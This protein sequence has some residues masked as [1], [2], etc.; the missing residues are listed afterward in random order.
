MISTMRYGGWFANQPESTGASLS[1]AKV[2]N[3]LAATML[4]VGT[5][6]AIG[7]H[8]LRQHQLENVRSS[9]FLKVPTIETAFVRGALDDLARIREVF[10]PAISDLAKALGVSRQAVYNWTNGEQPKPEHLA[11]LSDFAQAADVIA[12]AG[13]PVNGALLKRKIVENK[14]LF[15]VVQS[16]GSAR[17]TAQFLVQVLRRE[18]EQRQRIAARFS[19]RKESSRSAESDF[20]APNDLI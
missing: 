13:I 4:G 14:N 9:T 8:F 10:S 15:E 6:G 11:K 1:M 18:S 12:E 3:L 19:N 2:V 20:P 5:G 7:L 16:G 17:N